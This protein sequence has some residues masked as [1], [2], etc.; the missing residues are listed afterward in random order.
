M[1]QTS[2]QE[3]ELFKNIAI[4][5]VVSI[6][7]VNKVPIISENKSIIDDI[8]VAIAVSDANQN[9]DPVE[10]SNLPEPVH[11]VEEAIAIAVVRSSQNED[12]E[13]QSNGA[14]N[15]QVASVTSD[16]A[17][18]DAATITP[19]SNQEENNSCEIETIIKE[20]DQAE[21]YIASELI[22]FLNENEI[23]II[24]EKNGETE[25]INVGACGKIQSM[26]EL[27]QTLGVVKDYLSTIYE[28]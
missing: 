24:N 11:N 22:K 17:T 14:K 7:D 26:P 12:G 4:A 6:N 9:A 5:T 15:Q 28:L 25:K 19:G 23:K 8:A 13:T 18:S 20:A 3:D 2:N 10:P 21:Q 16:A 1:E 27:N